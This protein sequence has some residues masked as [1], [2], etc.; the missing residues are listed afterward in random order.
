MRKLF[1]YEPNKNKLKMKTE[2]YYK[3]HQLNGSRFNSVF[4]E[5]MHRN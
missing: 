5:C 2:S 4:S 1:F 3:E